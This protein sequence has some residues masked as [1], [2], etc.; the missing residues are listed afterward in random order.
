M[1][2]AWPVPGAMHVR[3][4]GE[5]LRDSGEADPE[6]QSMAP[7]IGAL[8]A[9][10]RSLSTRA[11][12]SPDVPARPCADRERVRTGLPSGWPEASPDG[13]AA[14]SNQRGPNPRI[15]DCRADMGSVEVAM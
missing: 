12:G 4:N 5:Y 3:G 11:S 14:A 13:P 7:A 2:T 8:C 1:A 10:F 9:A 15:L 6:G